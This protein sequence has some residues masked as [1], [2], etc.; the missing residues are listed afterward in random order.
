MISRMRKYLCSLETNFCFKK[1]NYRSVPMRFSTQLTT[2]SVK[3][4]FSLSHGS[5]DILQSFWYF[6]TT[7]LHPIRYKG[8]L[9]CFSLFYSA[10]GVDS[11]APQKHVNFLFILRIFAG[12][13]L[14]ESRRRNVFTDFILMSDRNFKLRLHV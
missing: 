7:H 1:C 8:L 5:L 10:K 4:R 3:E 6:S 14:R 12:N 2:Y 9:V 13:L 11:M